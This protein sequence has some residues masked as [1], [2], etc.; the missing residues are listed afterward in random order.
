MAKNIS[1]KIDELKG[2]V[3]WFYSDDFKLEEASEK[4]KALT[5]LAKEIEK[6]LAELKNEIKV[7]EEDFSK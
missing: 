2:G 3:E 4:Y 7:I 6:D 5:G 1:E